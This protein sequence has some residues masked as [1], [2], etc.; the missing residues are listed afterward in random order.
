M[1]I[2]LQNGQYTVLYGVGSNVWIGEIPV[3]SVPIRQP[4]LP[5]AFSKVQQE[6]RF[7]MKRRL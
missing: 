7:K 5:A 4:Y 1:K 3:I 2:V 6:N